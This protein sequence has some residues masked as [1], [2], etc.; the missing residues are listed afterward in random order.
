MDNPKLKE[1]LEQLHAALEQAQPI[2]EESRQLLEHL[3]GDIQAVLKKPDTSSQ[4]SLRERLAAALIKFEDAH[5]DLALTIK[6]VL[7]NLAQV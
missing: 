7:D 1:T 6:Q 4:N 2:D 3:K 5:P